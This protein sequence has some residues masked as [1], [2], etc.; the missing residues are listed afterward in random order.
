MEDIRILLSKAGRRMEM[1]AFLAALHV[2]AIVV[3]A[4][5]LALALAF[6]LGGREL[7]S[8]YLKRWLEE[9]KSTPKK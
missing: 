7:A 6:G 1:S 8:E 2:V 5:A 4:I 3:A 9:K